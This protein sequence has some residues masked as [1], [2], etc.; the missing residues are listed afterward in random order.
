MVGSW[1]QKAMSK[2]SKRMQTAAKVGEAVLYI[3]ICALT[4]TTIALLARCFELPGDDTVEFV[5]YNCPEGQYNPVASLLLTTS[6]G[7]VKRLFSRKNANEL[8]LGN[9]CLAFIAYSTL[10]ICLT[11]VPVPSGN[12]TGSMLIG[13]R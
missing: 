12:F 7:A 11:G 2:V 1:R 5:R 3:T 13:G 9:E 6:E 10:N 4:Y 8:H